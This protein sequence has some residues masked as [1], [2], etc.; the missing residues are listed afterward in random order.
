MGFFGVD[1]YVDDDAVVVRA[2]GEIDSATVGE[3]AA[4]LAAALAQASEHAARLMVIDLDAVTHFGSAGLNAVLD[5]RNKGA[6][7]GTKV[8]LVADC[9]EVVGPIE[10]TKL[11]KVLDVYP[12]RRAALRPSVDITR[13]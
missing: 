3:L 11:D 13:Q 9:A 7:E 2:E 5:C 12:T 6:A 8:R 10:L 4:A 1:W